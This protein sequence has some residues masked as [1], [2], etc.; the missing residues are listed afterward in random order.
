MNDLS[1][2][3]LKIG[4]V[5]LTASGEQVLILQ[6]LPKQQGE[7]PPFVLPRG[8]RQYATSTAEGGV[9]W[10][11]ARDAAT[12]LAHAATLEPYLRAL[13]REIEEEAGVTPS[14]LAD[15][16]VHA[17]GAMAFHSRSKGIYPIYWF[18]VVVDAATAA[19]LTTQTPADA[20]CVRWATLAEIKNM[21][22]QEQFSA[23]Y[24]PVIEAA[25]AWLREAPTP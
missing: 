11:D 5:V 6:P 25:L 19:Q 18:V 13:T 12:G 7:V 23:G 8:S 2:P 21:A 16:R 14:Q 17:L 9:V 3:I 22:A 1:P 10:Q 24:V 15:A 4:A 20:L